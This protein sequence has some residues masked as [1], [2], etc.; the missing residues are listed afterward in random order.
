MKQLLLILTLCC[1]TFPAISQD[2]IFVRDDFEEYSNYDSLS[3]SPIYHFVDCTGKLTFNE[4]INKPFRNTIA[5]SVSNTTY[6]T[7]SNWYKI[8]VKNCSKKYRHFYL[9][10][11]FPKLEY[12]IISLYDTTLNGNIVVK[13]GNAVS[14]SLKDIVAGIRDAVTF[15]LD[16]EETKTLFLNL[17]SLKQNK[18]DYLSDPIVFIGVGSMDKRNQED[19][20]KRIYQGVIL[21]FLLLM[22]IYHLSLFLKIRL[23]E[24]AAFCLYAFTASIFYTFRI[25]F[26]YEIFGYFTSHISAFT[27]PFCLLGYLI[28]ALFYEDIKYSFRK[29]YWIVLTGT[30]ALCILL[31][32]S[33]I[34]IFI[35]QG[36][37]SIDIIDIIITILAI[38]VFIATIWTFVPYIKLV[39]NKNKSAYYFLAANTVFIIC[40]FLHFLRNTVIIGDAL[41]EFAPYALYFGFAGQMLIFAIGL[42]DKMRSTLK[43]KNESQKEL[44]NQLQVNAELQEKVN[45]ELEQKVKERTLE[46]EQQKE[47]II[48]QS[49]EITSQRDLLFIQNKNITDS[50]EYASF[51]QQAMLTSQ[52]VLNNCKLSNFILYCPRDIVSGDFYWFKQVKNYVYIVAADCTGHGVPGAFMSVLGISLLNEIVG[53]RDLNSPA[54]VL[55]EMRKK[56]KKSLK[57]DEPGS[58]SHDGIDISICLLDMETKQL[59]FAGAFNPL[60]VVR[61]GELIEYPADRMPVGVHPKDTVEFTNH[62][63]QLESNDALYIFSDGFSSQFGGKDGK[64]FTRKRFKQLLIE[65]HSKPTET[66]EQFLKEKLEE[67]QNGFEQVDDILVIGITIV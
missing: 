7:N 65:A 3:P 8:I 56:L 5:N 12:G 64:Q 43:E 44:I 27:I 55:N 33:L 24:Y 23:K 16:V 41:N 19:L 67:W 31:F 39:I 25:G 59:Q 38:W 37:I 21:G 20:L 66:Q 10:I 47:E 22:F 9:Q 15:N 63:I 18:E 14:D 36:G 57:Q 1:V 40:F 54:T 49:E 34:Y 30:Y 35:P 45:R 29:S 2:T 28:M 58:A 4:I 61:K 52:E 32:L 17:H 6:T 11:T 13:N 53:K 62:E 50:I 42:A 26:G 48:T 46:I 60:L 51:I